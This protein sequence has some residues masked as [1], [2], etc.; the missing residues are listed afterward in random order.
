MRFPVVYSSSLAMVGG[1]ALVEKLK[2]R[3]RVVAHRRVDG[4]GHAWDKS[5]KDGTHGGRK[6]KEA[7]EHIEDF[8]QERV[9]HIGD[10]ILNV[11]SNRR[12]SVYKDHTMGTNSKKR[13]INSLGDHVYSTAEMLKRVCVNT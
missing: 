10:C 1:E 6:R 7:Y 9:R 3:R 5:A 2:N 4:V 12:R 11:S 8:L 13:L